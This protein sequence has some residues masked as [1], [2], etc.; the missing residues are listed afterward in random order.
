MRTFEKIVS[1]VTLA[2]VVIV[3]TFLLA[4]AYGHHP[5]PTVGAKAE[6]V[7]GLDY[8]RVPLTAVMVLDT[9]C[10]FCT[11]SIPALRQI[12]ALSQ[13]LHNRVLPVVVGVEDPDTLQAFV[14]SHKLAVAG[15][16]RARRDAALGKLTPRLL[17]VTSDGIIRGAWLGRI[18]ESMVQ[19]VLASAERA[20]R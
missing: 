1:I 13:R 9:A 20:I 19:E 2:A 14:R 17:L 8:A 12:A 10:R 16:Y 3:G 7:D 18:D 6:K 15:V 11:E 4:V 5:D